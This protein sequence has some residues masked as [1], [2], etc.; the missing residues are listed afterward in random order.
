MEILLQLLNIEIRCK[1]TDFQS[2]VICN[3]V[4][5]LDPIL[6]TLL[7][8]KYNVKYRFISDERIKHWPIINTIAN[9]YD[10]IYIT[11]DGRGVEQIKQS[12]KQTDNICIFPEGTLYYKDMI[13]KSNRI[14]D[15]H[16]VERFTNVLSP[17]LSGF[18]CLRTI[19]KPNFVT[20]IT[21]QYVFN[22]VK[23]F[24]EPLT[25]ANLIANPPSKIIITVQ[26]R[27]IKGNNFLMDI[28][29]KKDII[30]AKTKLLY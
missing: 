20:D 8:N 19:L 24:N 10:T 12:V 1:D 6:L 17:K 29:R 4:S 21:L 14:C 7:F 5:E 16:G 11:R 25:I 23:Q 22:D 13:E 30:I 3:H 26:K 9:H 2:I 27:R 15:K 28:F 18:N